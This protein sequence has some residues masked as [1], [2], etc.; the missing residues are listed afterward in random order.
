MENA[1]RLV[2]EGPYD[3]G[4]RRLLVAEDIPKGVGSTSTP[5]LT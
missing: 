1:D 3:R 2:P 5:R 4:A